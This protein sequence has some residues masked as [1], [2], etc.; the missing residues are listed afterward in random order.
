MLCVKKHSNKYYV[1]M[2]YTSVIITPLTYTDGVATWQLPN[3]MYGEK[4]AYV[5]V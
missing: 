4:T 1:C 5:N 3:D 2:P